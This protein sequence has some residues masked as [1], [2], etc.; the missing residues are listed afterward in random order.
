M[1]RLLEQGWHPRHAVITRQARV[2]R[3]APHVPAMRACLAESLVAPL[4]A[5]NISATT[6]D[7]LGFVGRKEGM[8]ADA[9]VLLARKVS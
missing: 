6:A 1:E 9:V 5:V 2:A 8:A 4:A 7:G 3:P